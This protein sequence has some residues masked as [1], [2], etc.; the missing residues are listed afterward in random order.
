MKLRIF[1]HQAALRS[2]IICEDSDLQMER[3]RTLHGVD[4]TIPLQDRQAAQP[5][6]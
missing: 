4:V 2:R 5:K 1:A 6:Q 3:V